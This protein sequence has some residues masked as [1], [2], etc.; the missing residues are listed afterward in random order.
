LSTDVIGGGMEWGVVDAPAVI[1]FYRETTATGPR[2]L[3]LDLAFWVSRENERRIAIEL[4]H[5]GDVASGMKLIDAL[6]RIGKPLRDTIAVKKY[7]D[8]Q[9]QFDDGN[10]SGQFHYVKGGFVPEVTPAFADFLATRFEPQR[11]AFLY[12]QN[13]SGAVGDIAPD[14]TAF[15]NR[16]TVANLMILSEWGDPA[17]TEGMRSANRATWDQVAPF[18]AGYYVNLSDAAKDSA[19]RNY[20]AN[21]PR[22]VQLKKKFDPKNLFRLNSN[23][24]PA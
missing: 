24:S 3:S 13:A 11:G 10:I 7:V 19:S 1:D 16:K 17:E 4:C 15:W 5:A 9:R 14:A 23:V 2:E 21:Y 12:L 8:V 6:R 18:T 22:L 20:G